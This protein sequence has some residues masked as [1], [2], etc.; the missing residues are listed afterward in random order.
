MTP[1]S[2]SHCSQRRC[3]SAARSSVASRWGASAAG[4]GRCRSCA[5]ARLLVVSGPRAAPLARRMPLPAAGHHVHSIGRETGGELLRS[6]YEA[7]PSWLVP[8][9]RRRERQRSD[10]PHQQVGGAEERLPRRL[11]IGRERREAWEHLL[12]DRR[13]G[14]SHDAQPAIEK[15]RRRT[16]SPGARCSRR[17]G[18]RAR[19]RAPGT[20]RRRRSSP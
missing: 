13:L 2:G 16:R 19:R 6:C 4:I 10:F 1:A 9:C 3:A 8:I 7:A 15:R 18:R 17:T 20:P 11:R 5:I 12:C 14:A